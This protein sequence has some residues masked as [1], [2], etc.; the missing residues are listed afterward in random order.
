MVRTRF[1]TYIYVVD[2][3]E[4]L[5]GI[6]TSHGLEHLPHHRDRRGEHG[7][8]ARPGDDPDSLGLR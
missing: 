4:R 6:V 5:L 2:P 1:I 8:A 3:A 7:H